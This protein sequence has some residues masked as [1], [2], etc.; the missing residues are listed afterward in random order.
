VK[1]DARRGSK[2]AAP[3]YG[4]GFFIGTGDENRI[5]CSRI[6]AANMGVSIKELRF[7]IVGTSVHLSK[8]PELLVKTHHFGHLIEKRLFPLRYTDKHAAQKVFW[9]EKREFFHF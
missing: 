5:S 4:G 8:G 2:R 1:R 6:I 7:Q 3:G 9:Q